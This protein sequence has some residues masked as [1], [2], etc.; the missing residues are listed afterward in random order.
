MLHAANISVVLN[1][2]SLRLRTLISTE[3]N[4][5][6]ML[7]ACVAVGVRG[8]VTVSADQRVIRSLSRAKRLSA[9]YMHAIHALAAY[10][11]MHA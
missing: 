6:S 11:S 7:M 5:D 9:A 10:R 2:A 4:Y 3:T 8:C 1:L